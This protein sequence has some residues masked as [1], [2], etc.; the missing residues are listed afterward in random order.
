MNATKTSIQKVYELTEIISLITGSNCNK[1]NI[2]SDKQ[3]DFSLVNNIYSIRPQ[4]LVRT[5]KTYNSIEEY[6]NRFNDV[7]QWASKF[8][9]QQQV[10]EKNCIITIT[11]LIAEKQK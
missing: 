1:E 5:T 3:K 7:H 2:D 4:S 9:D 8:Y 11:N 10:T 6:V